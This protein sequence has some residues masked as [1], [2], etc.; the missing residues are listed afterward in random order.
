M[1]RGG[2]EPTTQVSEG[3]ETVHALDREAGRCDG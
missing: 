2:F 1:P 3:A